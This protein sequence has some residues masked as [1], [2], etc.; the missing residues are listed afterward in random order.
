MNKDNDNEAIREYD[1]KHI[2]DALDGIADFKKDK[3]EIR[4]DNSSKKIFFIIIIILLIVGLIYE[5][6]YNSEYEFDI[7]PYLNMPKAEN[8][9][10]YDEYDDNVFTSHEYIIYNENEDISAIKNQTNSIIVENEYLNVNN[11]LILKIKNNN[12]QYISNFTVY[13]IFYNNENEIIGIDSYEVDSMESNNSCFVKYNKTPSEYSRYEIYIYKEDFELYEPEN[14]K[15]KIEYVHKK[16]DNE[17][18]IKAKNNFKERYA[19]L[20]FTVI[21]YDNN[22]KILDID[23]ITGY[24]QEFQKEII[25]VADGIIDIKTEEDIEYSKY[26]V[27]LNYAY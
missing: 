9:F 22:D 20:N 27:I 25:C 16:V 6:K 17:V 8:D 13:A 15:E 11:Q 4:K 21:Y 18:V 23:T 24:F 12:Q 2:L 19:S 14:I 26:D 1:D 3:G 7:K 5:Y 10:S